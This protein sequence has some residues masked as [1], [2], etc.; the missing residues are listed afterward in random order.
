VQTFRYKGRNALGDVLS[1]EIDAASAQ[2]VAKWMHDTGVFPI[3]ISPKPPVKE[4]PPWL[5]RLIGEDQVRPQDLLLFTR[6]MG[7]MGRSGL[8]LLQAI[9]GLSR[10]SPSKALAAVL[11]Q[12]RQDLDKGLEFSA[13]LA[14]HPKVFDDYYISMVRVGENAGRLDEAFADLQKQLQF[15]REMSQRIRSALRYPSFVLLAIGVAM[16][17][18]TAFV[19]PAFAKTY[20]GLNVELPALTRVLLAISDFVVNRWWVILVGGAVLVVVLR[21]FL[22]GEQG[23][24]LWD[25]HKLRLPVFGKIIQKGTVARFCSGFATA[26]KSGVP[27]VQ[28][29]ELVTRVVDNAFY[30]ARIGLMRKGLE[31]GE[32]FERVARSAGVFTALELQMIGVGEDSGD[33]EGMMAQIARLYE[34]DVAYDVSRLSESLEPI[35]LA[36]MGGM[37]GVLLLGIFLPLWGLGDAMLQGR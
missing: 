9:E 18:L 10:S 34:E 36:L 8:P 33:I 5:A 19:I 14:R 28:A 24:Y 1:G 21:A 13:A 4:T 22:R 31:R 30:A 32:S 26:Y 16:A 15:D 3:A 37:V 23:R 25:K 35:L 6:Q 17:V 11:R 29:L 2:A 12:V 27:I 20:Q 7:S